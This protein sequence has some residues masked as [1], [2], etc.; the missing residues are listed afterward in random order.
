MATP[1][2]VNPVQIRRSK[3][4]TNISHTQEGKELPIEE[5]QIT[6]YFDYK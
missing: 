6:E 5:E 1:C 4:V 2:P 3:T